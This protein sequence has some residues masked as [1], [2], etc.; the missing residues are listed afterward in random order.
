MRLSKSTLLAFV[1]CGMAG[2]AASVASAQPFMINISGATLQEDFFRSRASFNDFCDFDGDGLSGPDADNLAPFDVTTP[3]NPDL[4]WHVHYRAVGSGNG[5]AELVQWGGKGDDGPYALTPSDLTSSVDAAYING[6][7]IIDGS[8]LQPDANAANPGASP[9]VTPTDGTYTSVTGG[10]NTGIQIDLAPSDV[11]VSWFR[12]VPTEADAD[13][14]RRPTQAGYGDNP[15]L[16][17]DKDGCEISF[18]HKLKDLGNL[19][20]NLQSPDNCTLYSTPISFTPLGY[21]TNLGTGLQ[22][23]SQTELRHLFT[24]GRS[25]KGENFVAVTRDS[26]S[27]TRNTAMNSL[28][29]DPSWGV[30]DNIGD[31]SS[32]SAEELAGPNYQP[33]NKGGSSRL[34]GSVLAARLGVGYTGAE[35]GESSD[36]LLDGELEL[37]AVQF[38]LTA[39]LN[40]VVGPTPFVR[41]TA[42]NVLDND[43]ASGYMAGG[44]AVIAHIG[45][46]LA[47]P[48]ANGGVSNGNPMMRNQYAAQYMN[49]ITKSIAAFEGDPGADE[50]LFSPGE[51]LATQFIL[52]AATDFRVSDDD[53]CIFIDARPTTGDGTLNQDLQDFTRNNSVLALPQFASFGTVTTTGPAPTRTTGITYSDGVA[54]GT[55]YIDQSGATVNYGTELSARNRISGDFNNDGLR[56]LDDAAEMIAAYIDRTDGNGMIDWQPG[57]DAIIE[58]LGDF[59]ADGN[60]DIEDLRYWADGLAMDPVTGCLD[61]DAGFTALDTEFGGNLFNTV[62][63]TGKAYVAGDSRADVFNKNGKVARGF[64]PVGADGIVDGND[65]DYVYANF[66]D[67]SDLR[68]AIAMDLSC[69]MN[70][71]LIV[72]QTDVC[73]VVND[74][75]GTTFGDVNL[76]GSFTQADI[77]I[78]LANINQAGGWKQGDVDGDGVVTQNDLDIVQNNLANLCCPTDFDGNGQTG[79]SDLSVLL[80]NWGAAPANPLADLAN[81]DDIINAADLSALLANWGPCP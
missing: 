34:E 16:N 57:T 32:D 67:W 22:Q 79:A 29:L 78:V 80:A 15:R 55:N 48:P 73:I 2:G 1:A 70:G 49:N 51:L 58:V 72:D 64:A 24:T 11:P 12:T 77:D 35:R 68:E 26:G 37:L 17:R 53:N 54:G 44:P 50:T 21:I 75:L 76:D 14:D 81:D 43:P 13:P 27:G 6:V 9:I 41:P 28:C 69:D 25:L 61:R 47:E 19:N 36:W 46:P 42:D 60:F 23:A 65:I 52:V 30:G 8:V 71:D 18:G 31:K 45:D 40:G 33:T 63:A 59:Q 20:T 5:I 74:V 38:D 62:L 10:A 39:T 4:F 56:N 66:G 7:L 3:F